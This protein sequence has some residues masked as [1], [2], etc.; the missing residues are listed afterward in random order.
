VV[1]VGDGWCIESFG[2]AREEEWSVFGM[3]VNHLL[4]FLIK[5]PVYC[6]GSG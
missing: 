2:V 1:G 6:Y 4:A 5:F 3:V